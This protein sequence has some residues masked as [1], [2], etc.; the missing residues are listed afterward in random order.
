M[1]DLSLI[2]SDPAGFDAGLARRSMPPMTPQILALD[3]RRR[4]AQTELQGMQQRRNEAS[5]AIGAAKSKGED[6]AALQDEVATLKRRMPEL[7]AEE[8]ALGEA[9]QALLATLPNLPDASV[10]DGVDE[11]ANVELRRVGQPRNF[12]AQ[13]KDHV[14]L[15]EALGW[16]DVV[17][18]ARL[19]CA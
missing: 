13:P 10:P 14:A 19:S 5:R 1:H 2:R 4:A 6:T 18:S 8:K 3:E 12:V 15:G 7:E 17:T 16:M 11:T 9:L